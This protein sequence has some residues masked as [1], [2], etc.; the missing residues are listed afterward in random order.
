MIVLSTTRLS[1]QGV[2][3]KRPA[4]LGL[5]RPFKGR[6][7]SSVPKQATEVCVVERGAL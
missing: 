3:V 4:L 7:P 5:A 1:L 2:S 6:R